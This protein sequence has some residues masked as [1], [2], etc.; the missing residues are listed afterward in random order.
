[1]IVCDFLSAA[2][3]FFNFFFLV[4]GVSKGGNI[5]SELLVP[6]PFA[7]FDSYR[8]DLQIVLRLGSQLRSEVCTYDLMPVVSA[9]IEGE[10][11]L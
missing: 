8:T 2:F 11:L 9:S 4:V 6:C 3:I 5:T 7:I 1:M 10:T